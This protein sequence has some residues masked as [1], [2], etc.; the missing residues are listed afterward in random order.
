MPSP[1]RPTFA[2]L[3]ALL[4]AVPAAALELPLK[5]FKNNLYSEHAILEVADDGGLVVVDYRSD[6]DINGRD[7]IPEK[8]VKD[9]YVS[10][11]VNRHQVDETLSL[12]PHRLELTRVGAKS[13]S[14][15]SVI[16]LHGR[17]GDR[18]LGVDD[19]TFGGNFNRLKNL[20]VQNGGSYYAPTVRD[21]GAAGRD[22][23]GRLIAEVAE[24]AP[25]APIILACASMGS[26]ICWGLARDP[27][28]VAHL[29]GLAIIGGAPNPDFALSAAFARRVPVAFTHGGADPVYAADTQVALFR[30]LHRTGYPTRFTLFATGSHGTPIRMTD[31]WRTLNWFLAQ[32]N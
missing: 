23:V 14:A 29:D 3:A 7:A 21:F 4:L 31:W 13:G 22:A 10:T 30:R 18:R 28:V 16:F 15:F 17:G 24:R 6:R 32:A 2:A 26:F 8:R 9:V 1:I 20:V 5:P 19:H 25:G 12:G 27:A 11:R